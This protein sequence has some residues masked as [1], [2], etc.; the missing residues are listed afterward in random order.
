M[1]RIRERLILEQH[2]G[3]QIFQICQWQCMATQPILA[4][5]QYGWAGDSLHTHE[6]FTE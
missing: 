5:V 2:P 1:D 4:G 6:E 3:E